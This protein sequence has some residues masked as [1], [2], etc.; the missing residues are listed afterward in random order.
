M[1]SVYENRT[2]KTKTENVYMYLYMQTGVC[3]EVSPPL[4]INRT[5]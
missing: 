4:Y 2:F 1:P 3:Q 5:S